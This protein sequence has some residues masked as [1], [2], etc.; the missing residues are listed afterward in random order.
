MNERAK[1]K[2]PE[3][4]DEI[5]QG[6]NPANPRKRNNGRPFEDE[7]YGWLCSD[8][9]YTEI[10][11]EMRIRPREAMNPY[12]VDFACFEFPEK[13]AFWSRNYKYLFNIPSLLLIPVMVLS[14]KI[15]SPDF[16]IAVSVVMFIYIWTLII[17]KHTIIDKRYGRITW[18]ECRDRASKVSRRYVQEVERRRDDAAACRPH[19]VLIVSAS[20]FDED[21]ILLARA[22]KIQCWEKQGSEFVRVFWATA[23][24]VPLDAFP[25][26]LDELA[27]HASP[28]SGSGKA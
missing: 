5:A 8:P 3:D 13:L 22:Y 26:N 6:P 12:R 24:G 21:A 15:F 16:G 27:R 4:A 20:G 11:P 19:Q 18:V 7:V 17:V 1:K 9:R 25:V 2:R 23:G 28:S 10:A 14:A